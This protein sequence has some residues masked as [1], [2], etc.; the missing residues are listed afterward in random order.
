M[1][2]PGCGRRWGPRSDPRRAC[3][4]W[5][6]TPYET[7]SYTAR[8]IPLC[9]SL[10]GSTSSTNWTCRAHGGLSLTWT[11]HMQRPRAR[12]WHMADVCVRLPIMAASGVVRLVPNRSRKGTLANHVRC[13]GVWCVC[14]CACDVLWCVCVCM[15]GYGG[16]GG[17]GGEQGGRGGGADCTELV[18]RTGFVSW[19]P[20]GHTTHDVNVTIQPTE[21]L[22]QL[23]HRVSS[24]HNAQRAQIGA[25]IS[26]GM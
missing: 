1:P 4:A 15:G 16:G 24:A 3:I 12:R 10:N 9:A 2:L 23:M 19:Q 20:T 6:R 7:P 25:R 5:R 14:V 26:S 22:T 17:G 21:L 18:E 13:N 8:K 11:R